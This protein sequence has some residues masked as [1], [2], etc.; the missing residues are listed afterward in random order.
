MTDPRLISAS[1]L[2]ALGADPIRVHSRPFAVKF[3]LFL[4]PAF[5]SL[6][7][8]AATSAS[9]KPA[10]KPA[11]P[12]A[13]VSRTLQFDGPA[14]NTTA[15]VT[16]TMH[17][18]LVITGEKVTAQLKTD[19]PLSGTGE[20]TGRC[21][22]GWCELIGKL[23]DNLTLKFRGVMNDRDFRGLYLAAIPGQPIQYGNFQLTPVPTAPPA[24]T[25]SS[26][27]PKK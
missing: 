22:G 8:T 26:P 3:L 24:P 12:P 14:T 2:R 16:A 5:I 15:E 10:A 9:P 18:T 27:A 6:S 17:L 13:P 11:S 21:V 25:A 4:L 19:A 7:L 1:C 20:L 23:P